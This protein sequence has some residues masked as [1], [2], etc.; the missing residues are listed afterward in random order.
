MNPQIHT[1]VE[2]DWPMDNRPGSAFRRAMSAAIIRDWCDDLA[3]M[4]YHLVWDGY[5]R[6][7]GIP[8]IR[9]FAYKN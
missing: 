4:E 2:C 5:I 7:N 3:P 1:I 6:R 9:M 8:V